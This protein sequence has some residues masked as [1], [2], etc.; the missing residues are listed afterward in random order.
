MSE[1]EVTQANFEGWAIV[2]MMGHRKEIGYVTTQAFGPA[3]LFR[4]DTPELPEREFV[5]TAPEYAQ[6]E[7]DLRQWC[8]A[9][10]KVKRASS[11]AR[12]CLVAPASLYA[13]NPCSEAAARTAIERNVERPLIVL[14]LPPK[15][16]LAEPDQDEDD[17]FDDEDEY[18]DEMEARQ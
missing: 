13:M 8:P 18:M 9:G 3:V 15:A 2:E 16:L 1:A 4:V 14:E 7:R 10:T 6:I 11:P 5:L 12:S 17:G